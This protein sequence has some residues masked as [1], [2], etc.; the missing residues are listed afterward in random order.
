MA[1]KKSKKL[2]KGTIYQKIPNGT[3]YYRF[4]VNGERKSVS[5]KTKNIKL[6]E[7][8]AEEYIPIVKSTTADTIAAHVKKALSLE[9]EQKT[10]DLKL[11]WDVYDEHPDKAT[12]ATVAEQNNYQSTLEEFFKFIKDELKKSPKT[13]DEIT[14]KIAS[15]YA[16]YLRSQKIAVDTHNRKIKRLKRIFKTLHEFLPGG[17]PFESLSLRRKPREEQNNNIRRIPFTRQ[18]ETAIL[19]AL[20]D[21]KH[22]VIN[23]PEIRV[24]YYLGM[25]TGQRFKDCVLMSWSHVDFN[26]KRISVVQSKTG[27][28]VNIPIAPQLLK[29]LKEATEW[30]QDQYV[31]PNVAKRYNE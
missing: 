21:P 16:K 1:E 27:K 17:N 9:E 8:N 6:A 3:Y 15:E 2:S 4:Q 18:Q 31:C 28:E 26:R 25:F 23:K 14:P 22:K 12:P 29:V 19:K 10:L 24:V 11:A 30:K 5:L 13:L 7:K 20:D